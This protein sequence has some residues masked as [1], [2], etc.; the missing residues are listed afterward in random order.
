MG[1][2]QCLAVRFH[3]SDYRTS[4]TVQPPPEALS[5]LE[6]LDALIETHTREQN[7]PNAEKDLYVLDDSRRDARALANTIDG[8]LRT[9]GS[10]AIT[11]DQP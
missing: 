9:Y 5:D 8:T 7:K 3:C 2:G 6:R 10:I 4:L 11:K 1:D